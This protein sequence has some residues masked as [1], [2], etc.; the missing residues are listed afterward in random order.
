M[1][2]DASAGVPVP[3]LPQVMTHG[4]PISPQLSQPAPVFDSCFVPVNVCN[5]NNIMG[6][7]GM[8]A[9]YGM[10]GMNGV[11]MNGMGM[12]AMN[13]F[14]GMGFSSYPGAIPPLMNGMNNMNNMY[15]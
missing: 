3:G 9:M 14:S 1:K 4:L 15:G 12:N 2:N 13:P 5:S 6:G 10:N 7:Y 8:G 11:A